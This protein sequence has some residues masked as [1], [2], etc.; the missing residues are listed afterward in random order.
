[1]VDGVA[2]TKKVLPC[3][4]EVKFFTVHQA[5]SGMGRGIGEDFRPWPDL[6]QSGCETILR[7]VLNK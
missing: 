1:M 4:N 5:L 3:F 6:G 7:E 2:L